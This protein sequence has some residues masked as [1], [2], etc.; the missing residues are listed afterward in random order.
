MLDQAID[1]LKLSGLDAGEV[2]S[3]IKENFG[4]VYANRFCSNPTN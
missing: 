4:T 3:I 2:F 1:D